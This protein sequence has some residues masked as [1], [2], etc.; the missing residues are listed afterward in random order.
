MAYYRKK[1]YCYIFVDKF[2]NKKKTV[3]IM[4]SWVNM[5]YCPVVK[6]ITLTSIKVILRCKT[7]CFH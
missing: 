3:T 2:V 7:M 6:E 4:K 1:K 5:I